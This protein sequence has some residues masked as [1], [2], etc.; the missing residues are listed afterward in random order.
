MLRV[1]QVDNLPSYLSTAQRDVG[2]TAANV[3]ESWHL[4][5]AERF[6]ELRIIEEN[7][8]GHHSQQL[9][10]TQPLLASE[11]LITEPTGK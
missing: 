1:H 10:E 11:Y 6:L 7:G 9:I 3:D 4:Q 2:V 5:V 8:H